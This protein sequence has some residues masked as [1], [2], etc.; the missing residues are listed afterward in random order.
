MLTGLALH[1][2]GI[3]CTATRIGIIS[4][5]KMQDARCKMAGWRRTRITQAAV[6][7]IRM[8]IRVVCDDLRF[9]AKAAEEIRLIG[10]AGIT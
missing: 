10:A 5:R 9:R 2:A 1:A 6:E 8:Q 4:I 3:D 7:R